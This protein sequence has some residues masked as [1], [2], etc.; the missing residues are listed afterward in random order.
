MAFFVVAHWGCAVPFRKGVTS[1]VP[2][3][4]QLWRDNGSRPAFEQATS[5]KE[6][7]SNAMDAL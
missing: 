1:H 5:K 6:V 2:R 4:D 3:F 7:L